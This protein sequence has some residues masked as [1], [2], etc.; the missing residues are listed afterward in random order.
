MDPEEPDN[1][2]LSR[3][4]DARLFETSTES[5]GEMRT[6]EHERKSRKGRLVQLET[7]SS[8]ETLKTTSTSDKERMR[9]STS[10]IKHKRNIVNTRDKYLPCGSENI[11]MFRNQR[12]K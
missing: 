3:E 12:T 8:F 4:N 6:F 7:K 11:S 10:T 2:M 5:N 9:L 1:E